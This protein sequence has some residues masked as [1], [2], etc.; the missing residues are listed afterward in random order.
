MLLYLTA[1]IAITA[2]IFLFLACAK[3]APAR[4][5]LYLCLAGLVGWC[6]PWWLVPSFGS[7]ASVSIQLVAG[8]K[9][10]DAFNQMHTIAVSSAPT[11]EWQTGVF[12]LV[13][14]GFAWFIFDVIKENVK[15]GYWRANSEANVSTWGELGFAGPL[16]ELRVIYNLNNA[17]STGVIKPVIWISDNLVTSKWAKA[18]LLHELTHVRNN[19]NRLLLV[20]HL[21]QRTLFWNL[22]VVGLARLARGYI[23]MSCDECCSE[24]RLE[25]RNEL[26]ELILC[27]QASAKQKDAVRG[28][29]QSAFASSFLQ[30]ESF[31]VSRIKHLQ[32]EYSMKNKYWLSACAIAVVSAVMFV[33]PTFADK[34][35]DINDASIIQLGFD[36][37]NGS[38]GE[39]E[40]KILQ[41]DDLTAKLLNY[42]KQENLQVTRPTANEGVSEILKIG[43]ST[44]AQFKVLNAL[45]EANMGARGFENELTQ[46]PQPDIPL[47][48][49]IGVRYNDTE[50]VQQTLLGTNESWAGIRTDNYRLRV[51]PTVKGDRVHITSELV[52]MGKDETAAMAPAF[53]T[54]LDEEVVFESVNETDDGKMESVRMSFK[55]GLSN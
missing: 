43:A 50:E 21:I 31:N 4:F 3:Q 30:K 23:E 18:V 5:K 45:V 13:V 51:L 9:I 42:S 2:I 41:A 20:I 6:L 46:A 52:F 8:P 39:T 16:P 44:E 35:S 53:I 32:G 17:C 28:Q 1:N 40:Y 12:A 24:Q 33:T 19:D 27:R 54:Y 47:N 55:V 36:D 7:A 29:S 48:I 14:V 15:L 37:G 26:T 49:A 11:F 25:Y 34:R 10:S 22:V 38:K